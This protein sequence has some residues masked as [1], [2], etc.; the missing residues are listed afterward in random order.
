MQEDHP[1]VREMRSAVSQRKLDAFARR[2]AQEAELRAARG[3]RYGD[4]VAYFEEHHEQPLLWAVDPLEIEKILLQLDEE[5]R[6]VPEPIFPELHRAAR[7]IRTIAEK[8]VGVR[9][10]H[11]PHRKII[12]LHKR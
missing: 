3:K 8:T 9:A 10:Q 11:L 1:Y 2:L 7:L 5:M 12:R 4:L 6:R